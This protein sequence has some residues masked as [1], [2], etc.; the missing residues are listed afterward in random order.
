MT[1]APTTGSDPVDTAAHRHR[2]L[3]L[4][5]LASSL[6]LIAMDATVLNVA[7]PTL[8]AD[9]RPGATELLWIVDAYGLVLAGLLVAM[10]GLGDRIGRRRLLVMGL[11]VFG[12][13]TIAAGL[14]G[15][16]E[17][18]IAARVRWASAAR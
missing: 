11:V 4:V 13:A 12:G 6:L 2:W 9:L 3:I 8:A 7:L 1:D 10:G 17:Q 15:S 5:V 16:S 18:L 14:S